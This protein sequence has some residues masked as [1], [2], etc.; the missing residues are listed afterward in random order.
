VIMVVNGG[1]L[2]PEVI[3]GIII[4]VVIIIIFGYVISI[5]SGTMSMI[6]I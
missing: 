2:E 4:G 3:V 5:I 1:S 6:K